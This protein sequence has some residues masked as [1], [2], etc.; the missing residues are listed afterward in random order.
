VYWKAYATLEDALLRVNPLKSWVYSSKHDN[1]EEEV[2]ERWLI[3]G[4]EKQSPAEAIAII[5]AY[6]SEAN[7]PEYTK[8]IA[9]LKEAVNV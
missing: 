3:H 4:D 5:E 9:T 1:F 8:A 2:I 7:D 6:D